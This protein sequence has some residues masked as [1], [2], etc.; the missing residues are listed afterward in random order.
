MCKIKN[1]GKNKPRRYEDRGSNVTVMKREK[2]FL[3]FSSGGKGAAQGL[4][5][6]KTGSGLKEK[7]DCRRDSPGFY[8]GLE[9]SFWTVF[10]HWM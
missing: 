8:T 10:G 2:G 7:V 3:P 1:P 4:L 6:L 9:I 5:L